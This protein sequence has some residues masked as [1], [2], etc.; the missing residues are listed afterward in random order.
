[1]NNVK[2]LWSSTCWGNLG[3]VRV[4]CGSRE[5]GQFFVKSITTV[6]TGVVRIERRK[7]IDDGQ[8]CCF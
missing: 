5:C 2:V 8:D 1:M 6:C 7:T 3:E 4:D